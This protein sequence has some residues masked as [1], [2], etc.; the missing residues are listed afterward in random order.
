MFNTV[1]P[2]Q[3]FIN[4]LRQIKDD[5]GDMLYTGAE[6]VW[7]D[8]DRFLRIPRPR[9]AASAESYV[10]N[11]VHIFTYEKVCIERLEYWSTVQVG[12]CVTLRPAPARE[13]STGKFPLNLSYVV[14]CMLPVAFS[15]LP[16]LSYLQFWCASLGR[17]II[18]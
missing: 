6:I 4:G 15:L 10:L 7:L 18:H 8:M 5:N 1:S 17:H 16:M 13:W 11:P 14:A 9:L 3:K 12:K 2:A